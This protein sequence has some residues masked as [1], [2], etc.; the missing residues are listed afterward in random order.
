MKKE[1]IISIEEIESK[2]GIKQDK[3]VWYTSVTK[4]IY[5]AYS[6]IRLTDSQLAKL[7]TRTYGGVEA[8][9][10]TNIRRTRCNDKAQDY[11]NKNL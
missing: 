3:V 9:H 10:V 7:I 4:E 1:K 6:D 2:K 5:T 8:T 11:V